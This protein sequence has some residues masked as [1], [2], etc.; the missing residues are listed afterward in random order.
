MYVACLGTAAQRYACVNGDILR[1]LCRVEVDTTGRS[2]KAQVKSADQR[3]AQIVLIVGEE[4]IARGEFQL[5]NLD[6]GVQFPVA[7]GEILTAVREVI[8]S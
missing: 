1:G 8:N 5:K 7:K 4:E 2:L 6:T 3:G